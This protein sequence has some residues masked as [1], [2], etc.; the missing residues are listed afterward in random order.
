SGGRGM[1]DFLLQQGMLRSAV[2]RNGRTRELIVLFVAT[3]PMYKPIRNGRNRCSMS[4]HRLIPR[5]FLY[6]DAEEDTERDF[7][8]C[9]AIATRSGANNW[10]IRPHAHPAHVQILFVSQGGG[11]LNVEGVSYPVHI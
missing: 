6:G 2:A 4:R 11:E 5:Y 9:E 7:L 10:I 8:H 1:R 3:G